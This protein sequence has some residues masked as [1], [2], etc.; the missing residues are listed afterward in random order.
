MRSLSDG[1]DQSAVNDSSGPRIPV[2]NR[3]DRR[4][5]IFH[6]GFN[7]ELILRPLGETWQG[8]LPDSRLMSE[9][10]PL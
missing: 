8:Y 4:Q 9:A 10:Q 6:D 7:R 1:L 5:I 2:M 3:G